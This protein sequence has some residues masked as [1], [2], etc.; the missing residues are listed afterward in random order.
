MDQLFAAVDVSGLQT[1]VTTVLVSF[2]GLA[3]VFC[4]YRWVRRTLGS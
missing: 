4:G 3:L 2:V 1:N